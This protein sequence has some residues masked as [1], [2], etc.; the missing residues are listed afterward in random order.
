[1]KIL[2]VCQHYWPEPY[3]LADTCEEMVRR[4]HTV[5]VI[6][7]VP[8]Y[9]MGYIYGEYR[10][11]QNRHQEHNG[12]RITRTFTIGRRQN[13][14]FRMLNY[15]SFAVSSTLHVLGMKE[16]HDVVYTNQS[17][18]VMMVNAALAYAK[19]HGKKTVLYCMDLWPASLAA[20]GIGEASLIYKVFGWISGR[21]YRRAD[22]ILVTSRMFADYFDKQFGITGEKVGYLPQYADSRF[23]GQL[24]RE[25]DGFTNLV[26]AGNVGAAQSLQTVLQ[27][28]KKLEHCEKLRWHIVGDG[29]ELDHL[30]EMAAQLSLDNVVFHGRRPLEEMPKY[31][32]MADAMLV[33]LTADPFISLTLPGKV[34]TYMAAGKPIIAA[35][36]GEIPNVI[37]DSGC[38]FCAG[39]ED[40]QGLADAV[41]Q[42]LAYEDKAALGVRAKVYYQKHFTRT[43]FMDHLE[44]ELKEF[45]DSNE[46]VVY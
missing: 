46:G 40:A 1:M 8:N 6:T 4:G 45:C 12:V 11:G 18:P 32:A 3:P 30:K 27:A 41:S 22:R 14:L 9:P 42:F 29:S 33:T 34:Q 25:A 44:G 17:S 7:G 31:Y 2:V 19:K 16:E 5:H 13:I 20:G 28:A 36:T 43:M 35:A 23:D 15:F 39:A 26:F 21:L 38:G 10:H 37:R 24:A